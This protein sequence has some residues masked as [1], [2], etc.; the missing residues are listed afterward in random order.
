[1]ARFFGPVDKTGRTVRQSPRG[2]SFPSIPTL[3]PPPPTLPQIVVPEPLS[4]SLSLSFFSNLFFFMQDRVGVKF[5]FQT[6][7]IHKDTTLIIFLYIGKWVDIK[8]V[9]YKK[10]K[11]DR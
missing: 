5:L 11:I 1:M 3:P 9:R 7:N 2:E 8:L 10:K 4:L 6:N